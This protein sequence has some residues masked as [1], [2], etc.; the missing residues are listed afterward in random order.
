[1]LL[2][3]QGRVYF[4]GAYLSYLTGWQ[5]GAVESAWYQLERLHANAVTV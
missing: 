3:P 1:M 5:A 2:D 4:A